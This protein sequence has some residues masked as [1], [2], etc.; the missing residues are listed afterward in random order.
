MQQS[1][2]IA[3]RYELQP[4]TIQL[5]PVH[6]L[7]KLFY[8]FNKPSIKLFQTEEDVTL[9]T[10]TIVVRGFKNENLTIQ[11][12]PSRYI[13]KSHNKI[14][15]E[16][17]NTELAQQI[18]IVHHHFRPDKFVA[19]RFLTWTIKI[20]AKYKTRKTVWKGDVKIKM[21]ETEE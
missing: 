17:Q 16:I 13:L 5:K 8:A 15:F 11:F 2:K 21:L 6:I 3:R 18:P 10:V 9:N 4:Q 12:V 1:W 19:G 14:P 20:E 7:A